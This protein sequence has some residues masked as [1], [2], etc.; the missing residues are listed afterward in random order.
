MV[1]GKRDGVPVR[2]AGRQDPPPSSGSDTAAMTDARPKPS[3]RHRDAA[4]A[5]LAWYAS[6]RRRL[7]WRAEPGERPDPYRVWLSEVML[8]QTTV[9]TVE[10]Y[11][12]GFIRRWPTVRDLAAADRGEVMEAWAGLG[13]YARARNL[14]ACAVEVA[15]SHGGRFPDTEAELR[16]LPGIGGYTAAAVAA[17]A[18]GRRAVVVDAN[19]E[20]VGAR[21]AAIEIPLPAAKAGIR[22]EVDA[23]TPDRAGD[24]AQALMD[25]GAGICTATRRVEGGGASAP[26]CAICPL[27]GT[28]R[29][30]LGNP[31]ALP[32]R[33]PRAPRPERRGFAVIAEDGA[34]NLLMRRRGD[35]GML[36]GMLVFPGDHWADG[37][38]GKTDYPVDENPALAPLLASGEPTVLNARVEHVFSHFR[39]DLTVV[40]LA[41]GDAKTAAGGPWIAVPKESLRDAALPTVMRKAARA[42][43][44]EA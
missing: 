41:I 42:A 31:A 16:R 26:R 14:H 23:M 32:V 18:F 13:Y 1:R 25:I 28:C 29:G 2:A 24:F 39:L 12:A 8:Q 4:A 5:A 7:P 6:N 17:I 37:R 9:A 38:P 44:F 15:E 36:G 40:R 19:I 20:R 33:R 10:G 22:A 35:D 3:K 27:R 43:G 34:G 21:W 30:R 11:F